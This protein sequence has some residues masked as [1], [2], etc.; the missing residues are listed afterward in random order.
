MCSA[1]RSVNITCA[2]PPGETI[3]VIGNQNIYGIAKQNNVSM[4]ELIVLNNIKAPFTLRAGQK[5]VLPA[6]K[7]PSDVLDLHAHLRKLVE[8]FVK[9]RCVNTDDLNVIERGAGRIAGRIA[10]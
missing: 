4:R 7:L 10:Q 2:G 1:S 5:L 9:I 6:D 3:T 8:H